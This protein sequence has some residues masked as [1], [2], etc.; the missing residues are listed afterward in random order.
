M[1]H[2]DD[3]ELL[4]YIKNKLPKQRR[5]EIEQHLDQCLQCQ[6]HY[7]EIL[8]MKNLVQIYVPPQVYPSITDNVLRR[9]CQLEP[10][11]GQHIFGKASF[12][13]VSVPA[14]LALG[15][16]FLF[17]FSVLAKNHM[18]ISPPIPPRVST[19]I[20]TPQPTIEPRRH[21]GL[22][23]ISICEQQSKDNKGYIR[24]CGS[25]FSPEA[26]V[27]L[28]VTV[29]KVGL[30]ILAPVAV[31]AQGNVRNTIY[32]SSCKSVPSAV[33]AINTQQQAEQSQILQFINFGSCPSV[34]GVVGTSGQFEAWS[35]GP[36]NT[37]KNS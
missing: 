16:L 8:L 23:F 24:I 35:I 36:A 15:V 34:T 18:V 21:T 22:P 12:R 13:V 29:P 6:E 11:L 32:I 26:Q 3:G 27:E 17:T 28:L 5:N 19:R 4:S 33:V 9:A 14:A 20:Q 7:C 1:R 10:T 31:N 30:T 37:R 2:P 25:N